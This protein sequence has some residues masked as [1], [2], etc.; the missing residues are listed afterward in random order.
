MKV[1]LAKSRLILILFFVLINNFNLRS[2]EDKYAYSPYIDSLQKELERNELKDTFRLDILQ[3]LIRE[4][5][6][7]DINI[8]ERYSK[9]INEIINKTK[10]PYWI[11][12]AYNIFGLV[13]WAKSDFTKALDYFLLSAKV[14]DSLNN[15]IGLLRNYGN[16]GLLN[17]ST[18]NYDKAIEYTTKAMQLA[19]K[20][21]M[22]R[23]LSLAYG[24]LGIIYQSIKKYKESL[25]FHKKSLKITQELNDRRGIIRNLSNIAVVYTSINNFF[26]ALEYYSNA[27]DLANQDNDNRS[28]VLLEGNL[29]VTY[30]K[31]AT[32]SANKP[33]QT[34]RHNYL[35]L[36]EKYLLKAIELAKKM[37]FTDALYEYYPSLSRTYAELNDYKKAYAF[38]EL[39]YAIK[40]S[41]FNIENNRVINDLQ[42]KFE[43]QLVEKENLLL[44]K[45]NQVKQITIYAS[46]V[47]ILLVLVGL[48]FMYRNN[49]IT[50]RLNEQL[51]EQNQKIMDAK[52]ELERLLEVISA[53]NIEL[54]VTN[55]ELADTNATK[56][57]LFSIISHDLRNPLQAILLNSEILTNFRNKMSEQDQQER[58]NQIMISSSNL[59]KLLEDLLQ[60]SR[61]QMN[62]IEIHPIDFDLHSLVNVVINLHSEQA[63][64][65][66]ITLENKIPQ[67]LIV[68]GDM[69]T[70]NTIFRNL[71]SNGIKFT[72]KGGCVTIGCA[73]Q[74]GDYCE[75]YVQD[76]GVGILPEKLEKLFSV[77]K[78]FTTR[79]T[80]N[81]SGTGLGLILVKE[82]VDMNNGQISVESQVGIGTTFKIKFPKTHQNTMVN[83]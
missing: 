69:S 52:I 75:I 5:I 42:S 45:D 40:D 7:I 21:K 32:D 83:N 28:I 82:F 17:Y 24:N 71:I 10:N 59:N 49:K 23:E 55:K 66:Q 76:N 51:E 20:L 77:S 60:W 15:Q 19:E 67:N 4:F 48:Y 36:S 65:K 50:K 41:L 79:G 12:N 6:N 22:K 26:D 25:T 68:Y 81:E 47:V 9:K 46:I 35:K 11:A 2:Q 38:N 72:N 1:Y 56:D 54:E 43:K 18:Q 39:Y 58:I 57:K 30:Y 37:N 8:A 64:Q 70:I 62:K 74:S 16:I 63:Q 3:T 33:N 13:Y 53:K 44:K 31:I 29:G 27:L 34:Q 78:S 61:S 14:N 73:D 80:N